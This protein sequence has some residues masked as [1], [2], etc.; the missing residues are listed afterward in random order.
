[1]ALKEIENFASPSMSKGKMSYLYNTVDR[2][3]L[4][5][6]SFYEVCKLSHNQMHRVKK[7]ALDHG[8]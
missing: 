5:K 6:T 7:T 8:I 2:F 4:R 1:M 3:N